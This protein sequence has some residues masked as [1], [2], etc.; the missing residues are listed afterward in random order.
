MASRRKKRSR[1]RSPR[2]AC[3]IVSKVA[4]WSCSEEWA[5][6]RLAASMNGN[7][8]LSPGP[9]AVLLVAALTLSATSAAAQGSEQFKGRS[10]VDALRVLQARG[11][12]IVFSSATV[13]PD[14][15]VRSEPRAATAR[16]Q[17]DELLAPHG[18][19][20]RDGPGGTIQ[21]V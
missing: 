7:A 13:T 20:A 21:V 17:L 9:C 1:W 4:S 5:R 12:Q 16:Q 14:L 2:A 18:L 19:K 8:R 6:D 11:L 10:L 15:R 3:G